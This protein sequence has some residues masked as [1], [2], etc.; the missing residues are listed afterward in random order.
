[1]KLIT[2]D[3]YNEQGP[4]HGFLLTKLDLDHVGT[5]FEVEIQRFCEAAEWVYVCG[6]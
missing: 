4:Y 3:L 2:T 1:M 5:S 6:N